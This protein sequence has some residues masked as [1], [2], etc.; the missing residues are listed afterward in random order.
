MKRCR[1][2]GSRREGNG[3]KLT[4]RSRG[5]TYIK[6][7]YVSYITTHHPALPFL[8]VTPCSQ[9]PLC[10]QSHHCHPLPLPRVSQSYLV[11]H[12]QTVM[13]R[14]PRRSRSPSPGYRRKPYSPSRPRSP[15]PPRRYDP[16]TSGDSY[17]NYPVASR[18]Y[19]PP[20]YSRRRSPP[21][22]RDDRYERY[23]R[24]EHYSP[25]SRPQ[26]DYAAPSRYESD[27]GRRSPIPPPR[28]REWDRA[29][30]EDRSRGMVSDRLSEQY[31]RSADVRHGQWRRD[32]DVDDEVSA[33]SVRPC[34][35]S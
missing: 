22:N 33:L 23:G 20:P 30:R 26:D 9:R 1:A 11:Q 16:Q 15:S 31:P 8:H 27:G 5:C 7:D 25:S 2:E 12:P 14:P 17:D 18:K 6:F 35:Y 13:Y 28:T 19:S 29:D 4:W 3:I 10:C 32:A 21:P 34:P 24:T